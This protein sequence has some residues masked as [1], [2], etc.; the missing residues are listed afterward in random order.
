MRNSS[1]QILSN[2]PEHSW[3]RRMVRISE[4]IKMNLKSDIICLQELSSE[5]WRHETFREMAA[6]LGYADVYDH[7]L[8]L[9]IMWRHSVF[10]HFRTEY[11]SA[12]NGATRGQRRWKWFGVRL[13]VKGEV[14]KVNRKQVLLHTYPI[15][16]IPK[17]SSL[18]KFQP[19]RLA[20]TLKP[21]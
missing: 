21:V 14:D 20:A 18:F 2:E 11:L 5:M 4:E 12:T 10:K 6:T 19:P 3:K 17:P 15:I 8:K 9:C 13:A 16:V 7:Q 1:V